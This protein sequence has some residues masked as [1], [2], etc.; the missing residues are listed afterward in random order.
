MGDA[1][2]DVLD[3][4]FRMDEDISTA[5]RAL[6]EMCPRRECVRR[7]HFNDEGLLECDL[8]GQMTDL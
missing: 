2:D 6:A 5:M 1:A 7:A 8:C 4:A 3:A